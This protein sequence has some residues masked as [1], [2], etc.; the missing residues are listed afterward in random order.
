MINFATSFVAQI[1]HPFTHHTTK[2][3]D[4][5]RLYIGTHMVGAFTVLP[6]QIILTKLHLYPKVCSD[7][8]SFL[9]DALPGLESSESTPEVLLT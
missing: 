7:G 2:Y 9:T 1:K 5:A 6:I 4:Y 8:P 3:Q